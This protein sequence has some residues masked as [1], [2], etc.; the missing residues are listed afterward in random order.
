MHIGRFLHEMLAFLA[1]NAAALLCQIRELGNYSELDCLA[2]QI[3]AFAGGF[4][5][6]KQLAAA[7]RLRGAAWQRH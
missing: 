4:Q 7:M 6:A 1:S 3:C 2:A 5:T